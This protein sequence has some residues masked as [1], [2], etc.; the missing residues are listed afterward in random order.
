MVSGTL[1][2][3]VEGR[4]FFFPSEV[5]YLGVHSMKQSNPGSMLCSNLLRMRRY[6]NITARR[7]RLMD[8][9]RDIG[10]WYLQQEPLLGANVPD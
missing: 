1:L 7:T 4:H 3:G 10:R 9:T 8:G 5:K 2:H 6:T